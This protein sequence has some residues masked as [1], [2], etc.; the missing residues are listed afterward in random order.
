MFKQKY[1]MGKEV[2][3]AFSS[4]FILILITILTSFINCG[5]DFKKMFS[6]ENTFNLVTNANITIMGIVS[7]IPLGI[8]LTKQ[9]KNADGTP[10]RYLQEYAAFHEI[11]QK[12][13][14]KRKL[15]GQWHTAQYLK[16]CREKQFNYLLK[17]NV[18]QPEYI[19]KLNI[20]QVK[21]LTVTRR[22]SIDGVEVTVNA[23]SKRQINAC[24]KVLNGEVVVHKLPD[25][26]F[27]Y[28]DNV[29]NDS[30]YDVAYKE[31]KIETSTI[32]AKVISKVALGFII[33]C[34]LTGFLYDLKNVQFTSSY[35]LAAILL[36]LVRIFNAVSSIFAGICAGQEF[37]YKLCYFING[38][39][40][41]LKIFDTE[42]ADDTKYISLPK[43]ETHEVIDL[44][45]EDLNGK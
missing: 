3:L 24:V 44:T 32:L 11:R 1:K 33:S 2:A 34:L 43:V 38:K 6:D 5:F 30:F 28:V 12:I 19:L 14:P 10:G 7:S 13:E 17:H 31:H 39:T 9:L 4:I 37:V 27:L 20:A 35:V 16:E 36:T 8:V 45:E 29:S 15:F 40:Q 41:F 22:F 21:S 25:F 42:V 18:L 23:L 26:Y